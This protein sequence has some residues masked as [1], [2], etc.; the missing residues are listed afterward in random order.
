MLLTSSLEMEDGVRLGG[1]CELGSCRR[2][3]LSSTRSAQIPADTSGGPAPVVS[4]SQARRAKR[5]LYLPARDESVRSSPRG[6]A[7]LA[8]A[9]ANSFAQST[10]GL[11]FDRGSW[12]RVGSGRVRCHACLLQEWPSHPSPPWRS[13]CS[14]RHSSDRARL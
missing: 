10:G 9:A 4:Q 5:H 1:A 2:L 12:C 7:R 13:S 11:P 14:R 6:P 3:P 8:D